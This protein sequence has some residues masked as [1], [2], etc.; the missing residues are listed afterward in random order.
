MRPATCFVLHPPLLQTGVLRQHCK[1]HPNGWAPT[2]HAT[3]A[4]AGHPSPF[5][6]QKKPNQLAYHQEVLNLRPLHLPGS[7]GWDSLPC[8]APL[9]YFKVYHTKWHIKRQKKRNFRTFSGVC[10][11]WMNETKLDFFFFHNTE[12][13]CL[14]A[15]LFNN[16]GSKALKGAGSWRA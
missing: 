11:S 15:A 3:P 1:L 7:S 2:P 13:Q 16:V 12:E 14:K 10:F 6:C 5:H 8:P 4:S 9:T